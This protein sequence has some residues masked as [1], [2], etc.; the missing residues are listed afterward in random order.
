[1][2]ELE[3]KKSNQFKRKNFGS[4][5]LL[6]GMASLAIP[7]PLNFLTFKA[8]SQWPPGSASIAVPTRGR[9]EPPE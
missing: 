7:Q 3:K 4:W 9:V 2:V 1:M 5:G 6:V 8:G